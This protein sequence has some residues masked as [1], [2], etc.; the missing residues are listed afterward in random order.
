MADVVVTRLFPDPGLPL[1]AGAFDDVVVLADDRAATPEEILAA[2][3]GCRAL[4][5]LL[6]DPV[7]AEIMDA[8]GDQ[9]AVIANYAVGYDNIDVAAAT[10]RGIAVANTPDVL[11]QASAEIAAALLLAVARHV[12]EGERMTRAGE[13][14]G[15]EPM[16]LLGTEL[17]GKTAGV[18]GAG[19]IGQAFGRIAHGFGMRV[20]YWGHSAKP[21]FE[22][23]VGAE[24][25]EIGDLI[26]ESDVISLH[27]PLKP[28]TRH[29]I[30]RAAIDRMKPDAILINTA[31]GPVVDEAALVEALREGRLGGAGLD[32]YER[33]P[34]LADGLAELSNVCVLPHLG[35]ATRE[36]RGA[37]ARLTAQAVID[38]LDGRQPPNLVNPDV[39][40]RRRT[41]GD[42][43][44]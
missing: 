23:A 2:V 12:R 38:V 32:V 14:R 37:M 43:D 30:D 36:A 17:Y 5:S 33:E 40:D 18:I 42:D 21:R 26:A 4:V 7:D 10:R 24:R 39:W 31:R 19:R 28:S 34:E 22:E 9:L 20:I 44:A 25:R 8:A 16:L 11:T 6:S 27:V 41:R 1:L 35:S 13:F 3:P 15:W 29:L